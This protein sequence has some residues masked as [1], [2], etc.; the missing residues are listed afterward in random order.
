MRPTHEAYSKML[1]VAASTTSAAGLRVGFYHGK[2]NNN[3]K[4]G[5]AIA[6][7]AD[8]DVILIN[9]NGGA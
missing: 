7:T 6:A 4:D 8:G 3:V 1:T 5:G 2:A 9:L